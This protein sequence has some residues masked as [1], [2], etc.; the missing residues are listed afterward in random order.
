MKEMRMRIIPLMKK[1][2]LFVLTFLFV[3]EVVL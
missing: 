3:E 1:I 2:V